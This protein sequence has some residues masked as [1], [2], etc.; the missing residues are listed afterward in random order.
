MLLSGEMWC[1]AC[2]TVH[3]LVS[4]YVS[5]FLCI[6][7]YMSVYVSVVQCGKKPRFGSKVLKCKG[8]RNWG[9]SRLVIM[10]YQPHYVSFPFVFCLSHASSKL[11][12]NRCAKPKLVWT[13]FKV[14]VT[15]VP[16]FISKGQGQQM[17]PP[18]PQKM[19]IFC[20]IMVCAVT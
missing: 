10:A 5:V 18:A 6:S 4:L 2:I 3:V 7:L 13:F 11:E 16:G 20:V 17:Q 19:I 14:G 12:N 9:T 1:C 8:E 15:G